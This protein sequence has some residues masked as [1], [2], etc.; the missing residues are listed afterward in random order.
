MAFKRLSRPCLLET[1]PWEAEALSQA[2][3]YALPP[4]VPTRH[5]LSHIHQDSA[6]KQTGRDVSPCDA[7]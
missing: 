5:F 3:A 6:R 1:T 2:A 4:P 7:Y